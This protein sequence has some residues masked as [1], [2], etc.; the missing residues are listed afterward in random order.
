MCFEGLDKRYTDN[1]EELKKRLNYELGVIKDMGYVDY[2]LIVVGFHP[3]C[4]G[5]RNHGRTRARLGSGKSGFLYT[6]NHEA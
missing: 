4:T 2:F 6:W 3:L 1:K 5:T